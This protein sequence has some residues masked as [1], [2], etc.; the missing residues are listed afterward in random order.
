MDLSDAAHRANRAEFS[1]SAFNPHPQ[2]FF[3]PSPPAPLP[4]GEGRMISG[5]AATDR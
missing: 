3:S 1:V 4:P 2:P 5:S